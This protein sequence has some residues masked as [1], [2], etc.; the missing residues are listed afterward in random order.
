MNNKMIPAVKLND[1]FVYRG[2]EF[3]NNISCENAKCD[4][5]KRIS[6]YLEKTG[7]FSL[8]PKCKHFDKIC[9]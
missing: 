7:N 9:L 4:L 8:H 1:S 6:D 5:V 3:C 2:K